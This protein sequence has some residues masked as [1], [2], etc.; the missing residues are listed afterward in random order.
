MNCCKYCFTMM[1]IAI[2]LYS[3]TFA[4]LKEAD[5][6]TSGE[7]PKLDYCFA[8][9]GDLHFDRLRHHDMKWV[10]DKH[11]GDVRQIKN[12]SQ[13]TEQNSQDL[14]GSVFSSL[15]NQN[16]S[17]FAIIQSGDFVEG[18]CGN[19]KLQALQFKEAIAFVKQL[20][21]SI[22]FL[23]TKGNHDITGPGAD[24]AYSDI[25]VPWLGKQLDSTI[26][27]TSY[28]VKHK[29]D[30]FIFFDAYSP[31]LDWLN[32]VLDQHPARY[33][34]FIIHEPVVPYNARSQWH[35]FSKDKDQLQRENLLSILGRY[36]A[37]VLSGHLH[38]YSVLRRKTD[39][40]FLIQ[41]A[42]NSVVDIHKSKFELLE[43]VDKY[44]SEL[45]N[46]EANFNTKTK[47]IRKEILKK[48][49]PFIDYFELAQTPCYCL[50][51]VSDEYI[52]IDVRL[53]NNQSTWRQLQI[54]KT[55]L[56]VINT[57]YC[58]TTNKFMSKKQLNG[59]QND[60]K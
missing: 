34:F 16:S 7:L 26:S 13:V 20:T 6:T 52:D 28:Y 40:G 12:Y 37:I 8:F 24:K 41:L 33:V 23:I 35:I 1:L 44:T 56:N 43:G 14:L 17:A 19:Y 51:K 10:K 55:T 49:K 9:L 53:R 59:K 22:P 15:K 30:L 57:G 60:N 25:I 27:G 4:D 38:H 46:L 36:H 54:N 5:F 31:N 29:S 21:P 47:Y 2:S 48:E 39:G 50:M 45:V 3:I 58:N 42:M 11:P 18:L 32:E